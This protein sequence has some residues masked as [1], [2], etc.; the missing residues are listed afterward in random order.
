MRINGLGEFYSIRHTTSSDKNSMQIQQSTADSHAAV[1]RIELS[2]DA[3]C[4]SQLEH[5][6]KQVGDTQHSVSSERIEQLKQKYA[7]DACP[8]SSEEIAQALWNNLFGG[9]T[10]TNE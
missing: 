10:K 3:V 6:R 9:G 8:I 1:D 7:G 5:L 4:R 2:E